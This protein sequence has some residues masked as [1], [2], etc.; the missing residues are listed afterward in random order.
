[1]FDYRINEKASSSALKIETSVDYF[2]GLFFGHFINNSPDVYRANVHDLKGQAS[3]NFTGNLKFE[4]MNMVKIDL[5]VQVVPFLMGVG[6]SGYQSTAFEELC[7]WVH[8]DF[9]FISVKTTLT[10]NIARC[11]KN[12]K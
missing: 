1:L 6:L 3:F 10:K 5:E 7:F 8:K 12:L 2:G 9:E 4:F 11:G